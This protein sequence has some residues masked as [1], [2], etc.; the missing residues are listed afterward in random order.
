MKLLSMF[1]KKIFF[2][3]Y[4]LCIFLYFSGNLLLAQEERIAN[5]KTLYKNKEYKKIVEQLEEEVENS[6]DLDLQ[7]YFLYSYSLWN[8]GEKEEA[9]DSLYLA[10]KRKPS[11]EVFSQLVKAYSSNLK[12]KGALEIC[13]VGLKKFPEDAK[14]NLQ[15]GYLLARFRKTNEALK[16]A[17][18]LKSKYPNDPKPLVLEAFV[19]SLRK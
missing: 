10:L 16:V 3:F 17:E 19:Y 1:R 5:L 18:G 4:I 2:I 14:L 7:V 12:Y 15:R 8:L 11:P 13:E 6:K 9:I